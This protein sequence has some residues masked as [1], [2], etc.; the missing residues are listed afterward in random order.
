MP[1]AHLEPVGLP[2]LP[3]GLALVELGR[4]L[5]AAEPTEVARLVLEGPPGTA[6]TFEAAM[7]AAQNE[8]TAL[9]T[10]WRSDPAS[11]AHH[12]SGGT[13]HLYSYV[14]YLS[15]KFVEAIRGI[16]V[17]Q[18]WNQPSQTGKTTGL[19]RGAVWALDDN[20]GLRIMYITYDADKAVREAGEALDFARE[21][22]DHLRFTLRR[23]IQARGRW[24]TQEG[25]GIYATGIGGATVG[26]PADVLLLDDLLK[27]WVEAHSERTREQTWSV[28]T[29]QLRLRLQKATDPII[30]AATRWHE[31]DPTG[32]ALQH[33]G[34]D[35]QPWTLVRIPHIAEA[36]DLG[37][38]IPE[39]RQADPLGRAPG[40]PLEKF[41]MEEIQ[42]RART[43][44]NYLWAGLEQQRPAP[45]EGGEFKR[46]WWKWE[47]SLPPAFDDSCSSWDTT[48]K[49]KESNDFVV[50]QVWG[51]TGSDFW[52]AEQLRGHWGQGMTKL[53]IA[54]LAVRHPYVDRHYVENTGN[55]PEVMQE[56]RAG[57]PNYEITDEQA[58]ALG[59]TEPERAAVQA[60][61]RRGLTGL[62]PVTPKGDKRVRMR[63]HSGKLEGGSMHLLTGDPGALVLV[64]EAAAVPNGAHEDTC[65]AWS[66]AMSKLSRG[67]ATVKAAAGQV[68]GARASA[69]PPRNAG[70]SGPRPGTGPTLQR[71]GRRR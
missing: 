28:Y 55:G 62:L 50:G 42:A 56:L 33:Q 5:L 14:R 29:S 35:V 65:D 37:H 6:D 18:L 67:A 10:P 71:L 25:G 23:D 54:L 44:G 13:Y 11:M 69:A 47:T 32:R 17:R 48:F 52:L 40:E 31:D 26:Y 2:G 57:Q 20:P 53:A 7:D 66:Q 21:H 46:A 58:G 19:M 8:V 27:G 70:L 45:E 16:D 4:W 39:M 59:M 43:L 61:M 24:N 9:S 60:V 3:D 1:L 68:T 36:P 22:R 63:A 15:Q 12:L 30:S 34:D 38:P 49:D 41:S 64:N 51:R